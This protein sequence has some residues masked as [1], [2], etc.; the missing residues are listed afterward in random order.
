[1][2]K[3]NSVIGCGYIPRDVEAICLK[4]N[5]EAELGEVEYKIIAEPYEREWECTPLNFQL[6]HIEPTRTEKRMTV[7]VLDANTGLTY[8][9][10]YEPANLVRPSMEPKTDK[11]GE[12]VDFV[13][14]ARQIVEELGEIFNNGGGIS[15]KCGVAFFSISDNG[16]GKTSSANTFLG[17]RGDRIIDCIATCAENS[18][19]VELVTKG[20]IRATLRTMAGAGKNKDDNE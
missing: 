3:Q 1:M 16:D 20:V 10:E 13:E 9:V 11:P 4:T 2:N 19:A 12:K 7:N 5:R 15:E 18:K 14:R 17:G 6:F 8:A